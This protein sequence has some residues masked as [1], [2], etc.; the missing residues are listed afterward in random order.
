MI[1]LTTENR[2]AY[3]DESTAV[4]AVDEPF[5]ASPARSVIYDR[6]DNDPVAR[7]HVIDPLTD[8]FHDAAEFVPKDQRHLLPR[9][10]MGR[11]RYQVRTAQVFVQV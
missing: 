6:L 10:W 7:L 3:S 11:G 9:D 1:S 4:A 5:L 8:L 2:T